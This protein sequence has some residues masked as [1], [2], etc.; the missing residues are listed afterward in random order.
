[1][2]DANPQ[3]PRTAPLASRFAAA[4]ACGLVIGQVLTLVVAIALPAPPS[5]IV[6]LG[7]VAEALA[8]G[9]APKGF[10]RR[11]DVRLAAPPAAESP[12]DGIEPDRIA[13]ALILKAP[14]SSVRLVAPR[15]EPLV[16]DLPLVRGVR[17]LRIGGPG[18]S[19][20]P[21]LGP[22]PGRPGPPGLG[23]DRA[24]LLFDG[25]SAA[26]RRPDGRWMVVRAAP[27]P[28][29]PTWLLRLGLW[30][31]AAAGI[32]APLTFHC[33]RRFSAP[34]TAFAS[35]AERLGRDPSAPPIALGGP[36]EIGVAARAFNQMQSR[37]QAYV[38]DRTAMIAA[39][40]HDLR[41][42]LARMRFR[43]E[44]APSGLAETMRSDI[45]QME[46]MIADVLSF[47]RDGAERRERAELDLLSILEC[48]VD[49]AAAS[50]GDVKLD[51][52]DAPVIVAGD[53]IALR[54]LFDN[55]IG[56]AI[57]YGG[58]AKV[59][60]ETAGDLAQVSVRDD[61]P[62]LPERELER[63]F[64]P[65]YRSAA[66]RTQKAGGVGLGL[67]VARSIARA[68]GGEVTLRCGA[69]GLVADVRLPRTLMAA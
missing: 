57:K 62:G 21:D 1:M 55:L 66:T 61:G 44:A 13:L 51:A 20:P 2:T 67:G 60:L 36:A 9:R 25:F 10:E 43:L 29:P 23:D 16:L 32:I 17:P 27:E 37:L 7:R 64:E 15:R 65:F 31:A 14:L 53:A 69:P 8:S 35:A 19:A 63:V 59:R 46:R 47:L 52:P 40:S 12:G 24:R 18:S 30:I 54:R 22:R 6:P 11:L 41:A 58:R 48:A 34:I 68:H 28:F 50:G 56:N 5:R 49:D 39:I 26:L 33:A 45:D 4:M 42:P 3:I 38:A